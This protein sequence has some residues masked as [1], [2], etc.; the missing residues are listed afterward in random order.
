[1]N[2]NKVAALLEPPYRQHVVP[3]VPLQT[4][5]APRSLLTANRI[6]LS[7]KLLYL[8]YKNIT[9]DLYVKLYKEHID[10]F[11]L[12]T[13]REPFT[14]EKTSFQ[15]Y[16]TRF[17]E[18]YDSIASTGF[19]KTRSIIPLAC[20]GSIV[21]GSHR[22][23]CAI[24]ARREVCGIRLSMQPRSY[25][26]WFFRSRG[27]RD[28]SLEIAAKHF[29]S[30]AENVYVALLWPRSSS[31]HAEIAKSFKN[32]IYDKKGIMLTRRG[33]HNLVSMCYKGEPWLGAAALDYP[34]AVSKVRGIYR[35]GEP[36]R[37]IAFQDSD[38][39]AVRDNKDRIRSRFKYGKHC[40]HVTDSRTEATLLGSLLF[41]E[42]GINFLN[43]ANINRCHSL[44]EKWLKLSQFVK[45]ND[46]SYDDFVVDS[47]MVL[48]LYGIR[49]ANDIDIIVSSKV[50]GLRGRSAENGIDLHGDDDLEYHKLSRD[51]LV[52]DPTYSFTYRGV[53]FVSLRQVYAAKKARSGP[54]DRFDLRLMR[55]CQSDFSWRAAYLSALRS[56][57]YRYKARYLD[58][59]IG[60]LRERLRGGAR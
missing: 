53:K 2:I 47:G 35:R 40:V 54:R 38:R 45:S 20:N 41:N 46:L 7:F 14:P 4:I 28:A 59:V 49:E 32:V 52:Y 48:E 36:L 43:F 44:S 34:G 1:M 55:H 15:S 16:V 6:D 42:N 25:N 12:G 29:V 10:A 8:S 31:E 24:H 50:V 27:M 57:V 3:D 51:E 60:V 21:N 56:R 19:D 17:D 23:A 39:R 58:P 26:W 22:T 30:H 9:T 33:A 18:L 37:V 5:P 11:T 13:F